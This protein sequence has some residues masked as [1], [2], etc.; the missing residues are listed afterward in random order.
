[1]DMIT[2]RSQLTQGFTLVENDF[3]DRFLPKAN[4]EFVK[5]YLYLL[6]SAESSRALSISS[7]A[8][9]MNCTEKD[10]SRALKYWE[11]E[12]AVFL[13]FDDDGDISELVFNSSPMG[14]TTRVSA[15]DNEPKVLRSSDITSERMTELG[16]REDIRELFFISQQYLGRP[17]SRPEMQKICFFYDGLDMAPDLIDF[18]IEYCVSRGHTSFHYIEKVAVNWCDQDITTVREARKS[19]GSYHKE[20]YDILKALG[21]NN[22]HPIEAETKLMKK[23]IEKYAFP[24]DIITEACTRTVINAAKPTLNYTD[25]ILSKWYSKG[26]KTLEDVAR[27]DAEH[28]EASKKSAASGG[29]KGSAASKSKANSFNDF[30]QREYDY[31]ALEKKLLKKG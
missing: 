4:G 29:K 15:F 22:H 18:L 7:I 31:D 24:M 14:K 30:E 13:S 17:L 1:M 8:D 26:V 21:I 20:Y 23:W 19:V 6:R 28:E 25:G 5:I 27:L 3:L 12:G 11:K 10:V 9:K 16:K 2:I